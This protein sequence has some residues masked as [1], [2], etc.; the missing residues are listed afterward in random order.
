MASYAAAHADPQGSGDARPTAQ[1]IVQD[2]DLVG[3]LAGC[4]AVVTGSSSGIG[5]ETA[6]ALA[7]TGIKLFLPVRDEAKAKAALSDSY[8]PERMEF[9]PMDLSSFESTRRAA[10][11]ILARTDKINILVANAG[12]LGG[13][14]RK[15]SADGHELQFAANHLSHFLLFQLLKPA[16]LAATTPDLQSRVVVVSSEAHRYAPLNET[17]NYSFEKGCYNQWL[18]YGQSKLANIYMASE[19]ERRYSAEGLHANSVHPGVVVTDLGRNLSQEQAQA[20]IG[21]KDMAP[22]WK[23]TE[24]GAATTLWAAV[25]REWEGKGGKYLAQCAVAPLGDVAADKGGALRAE[26]TYSPEH[27]ARLWKDSLALVGLQDDA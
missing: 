18:A 10:G 3:K 5:V 27:E 11:A 15:V 20:I 16:L 8:V 26:H 21:N 14:E 7:S 13:G 9:V 2:N 22:Y 6:R 25:D 24:Q 4:V 17:G 1:Q 19:I 12:V 23:N